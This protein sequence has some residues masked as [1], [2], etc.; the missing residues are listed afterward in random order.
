MPELP[1]RSPHEAKRRNAL[2]RHQK[3]WEAYKNGN[4][5]EVSITP[6]TYLRTQLRLQGGTRDYWGPRG[7]RVRTQS[8]E[9]KTVLTIWLEPLSAQKES[10]A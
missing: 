4:P 10:N 8:N 7:Y 3:L 5:I 6:D 9:D 2:K 1:A